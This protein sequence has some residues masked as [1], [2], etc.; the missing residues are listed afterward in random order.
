MGI[1]PRRG[2]L[3]E[4]LDVVNFED[5]EFKTLLVYKQWKGSS[6]LFL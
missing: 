2:T 1:V 3:S 5:I 4:Q 6:A